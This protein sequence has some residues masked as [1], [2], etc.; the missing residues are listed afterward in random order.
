MDKVS[1]G[2]IWSVTRYDSSLGR[3]W[4]EFVR[5]S[6]NATFLFERAYMDYHSDRYNDCSWL[7]WK[8][9]KLR[10]LLPG[11]VDAEGV[12]HSHGGLTYGGWLLPE[13]HL[14]GAD[15][16]RIFGAGI[17]SWRKEG[18]CGLDYKPVPSIY[19]S[20]P[21]QEDIYALF[22]LG[23]VVS[24]CNLSS[25]VAAGKPLRLN[26]MQTRHLSTCGA[27]GFTLRELCVG[28]KGEDKGNSMPFMQELADFCELLETCLKERHNAVPV[29]TVSELAGLKSD[30]PD[31]I[32]I[33]GAYQEG[34]LQAG[35]C[36]YDTG[37]VAHAQYIATT[38]RGREMNLLTPLFVQ[39]IGETFAHCRYFDFGISNED[40]GRV[41]N[42]GLLR[43]KCSY[44]ATG[45]AYMR[46]FLKI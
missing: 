9:N 12:L 37:I 41:L 3:E 18:I 38:A 35:V 45:V 43:Q 21:S 19:S 20:Q 23:G 24:E 42:E 7:A 44:G 14:D 29:H 28:G 16:L 33:F 4:D 2:G 8:G 26:K 17:E 5:S 46:Y 30:F 6:R 32:R 25:A 13:S 36:V 11:N 15:L 27:T 1:S 31:N 39:L 34:G 22:R 10:A 40:H